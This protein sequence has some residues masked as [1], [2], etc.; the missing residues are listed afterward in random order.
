MI[1]LRRC[2]SDGL[3]LGCH[4]L[5][6]GLFYDVVHGL[7]VLVDLEVAFFWCWFSCGCA[8]GVNLTLSL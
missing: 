7:L 2:L 5:L 8:L 1:N 4:V 6:V 3:I